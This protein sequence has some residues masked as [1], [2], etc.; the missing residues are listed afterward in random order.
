[1]RCGLLFVVPAQR[2]DMILRELRRR[3]LE[4]D[5]GVGQVS[6]GEGRV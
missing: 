6:G 4:R 1:M 5:L 2:V 3:C